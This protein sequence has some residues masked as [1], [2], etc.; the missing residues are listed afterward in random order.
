MHHLTVTPVGYTSDTDTPRDVRHISGSSW[1]FHLVPKPDF[2]CACAEH[3][4]V[5]GQVITCWV[6]IQVSLKSTVA[7]ELITRNP[8]FLS[9]AA[10]YLCKDKRNQV[11]VRSEIQNQED[12]TMFVPI[13]KLALTHHYFL[14]QSLCVCCGS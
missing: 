10:L 6:S 3:C 8:A 4:V 2:C 14:A 9:W 13:S 1:Y 12:K 7:C 5:P 11:C